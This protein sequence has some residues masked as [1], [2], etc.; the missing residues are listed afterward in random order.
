MP[1]DRC[2]Y[3]THNPASNK[4]D[5]EVMAVVPSSSILATLD[6]GVLVMGRSYH[7]HE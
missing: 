2:T 7:H 1:I 3:S 4:L 5:H 6:L